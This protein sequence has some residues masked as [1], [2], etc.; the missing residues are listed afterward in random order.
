MDPIIFVD[1]SDIV[2]VSY[3]NR[4]VTMYDYIEKFTKTTK[5]PLQAVRESYGSELDEELYNEELLRL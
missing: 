1:T 2:Q 5:L 4:W 3:P